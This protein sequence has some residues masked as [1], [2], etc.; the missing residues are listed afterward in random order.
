MN[1]IN[2]HIL[3][4]TTLALAIA[5]AC[6][7]VSAASTEDDIIEARQEAQIWTTFALSPYLRASDLQVRVDDG[8]ATITGTVEEDVNKDLA[9]QIALGVSGIDD[10]DNQIAVSADFKPAERDSGERSFGE[11]MD[12]VSIATAVKSK[13]IWSRYTDALDIEVESIDGDV[14][15]KGS[16]DSDVSKELAG[17]LATNT[18]GVDSVDN[19]LRVTSPSRTGAQDAGQQISDSWITAKVVS[20][21]LYSSN[22]HGRDISVSTTEGIVSLSGTLG[23]GA[24]RALAIELARSIRGVKDVDATALDI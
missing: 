7:T 24:E 4:K 20:S 2:R 6:A 18:H 3:A 17:K 13:L 1:T 14:T 22:V 10:V 12:D 11:V 5:T 23:G 16:T 9:R 15:L 19:Q 8:K 21:L